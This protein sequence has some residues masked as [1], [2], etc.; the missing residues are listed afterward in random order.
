MSIG[1][2]PFPNFPRDRMGKRC[3]E[4]GEDLRC[5][6]YENRPPICREYEI[7]GEGCKSVRAAR[8]MT[9]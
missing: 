4:L 7:G 8:G 9:T 5:A 6:I 1:R 2:P 3:S